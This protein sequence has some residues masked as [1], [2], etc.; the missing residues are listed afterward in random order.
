MK[1]RHAAFADV[2][3]E[4]TGCAA[5]MFLNDVRAGFYKRI[6]EFQ[7]GKCFDDSV[8]ISFFDLRKNPV[9]LHPH[10]LLRLRVRFP[11]A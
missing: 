1:T 5:R 2:P 8:G 11:A 3:H 9:R 6:F 4:R 10:P 7:P